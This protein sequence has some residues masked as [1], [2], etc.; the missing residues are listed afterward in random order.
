MVKAGQRIALRLASDMDLG[1]PSLAA[2]GHR[3]G[4]P[5][6]VRGSGRWRWPGCA[7][8][9][10]AI[11]RDRLPDRQGLAAAPEARGPLGGG[12][13]SVQRALSQAWPRG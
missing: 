9:R 8:A 11:Q 4:D 2:D 6:R 13:Y 7:A 1:R 12:P 3:C 10:R 5:R